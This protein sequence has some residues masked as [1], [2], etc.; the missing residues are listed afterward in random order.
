ML[1][2]A[3]GLSGVLMQNINITYQ[4]PVTKIFELGN[5]S[6]PVAGAGGVPTP[7]KGT[8]VYYVEGRPQGSLTLAR[9]LGFGASINAF[10]VTYGSVCRAGQNTMT[11][12][13]SNVECAKAPGDPPSVIPSK[14]PVTL[15]LSFCVLTSVGI[16]V[17]VQNF[18]VNENCSME[19]ANMVYTG[20]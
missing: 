17:T 5:Y 19:F 2:T 13:L 4:R 11:L 6:A 3:S 20:P 7:G 16:S 12:T 9:I 10:Y 1:T 15:D 8:N 14:I 18:V